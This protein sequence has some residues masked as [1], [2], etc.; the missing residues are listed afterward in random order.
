LIR[1][2]DDF[3]CAFEYREDAERFYRVLGK[4]LEKFG[5]E[6]SQ[7]KTRVIEFNRESE[8]TSFEFLGF[9]FRWS[10]DRAGKAHLKRRTARKKL[11]SSLGRFAEWCR[12]NRSVRFHELMEQLNL[13]LLQ[14]LRH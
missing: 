5:L 1:Y 8:K 10:K 2:A 14:L 3:V 12:E 4:R 13:K 6:L 9:E 7:A 11:C